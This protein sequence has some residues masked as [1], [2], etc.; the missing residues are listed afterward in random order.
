[1][2]R[3]YVLGLTTEDGDTRHPDVTH[4][5]LKDLIECDAD[6]PVWN[7]TW[8]LRTWIDPDNLARVRK[9]QRMQ[10][11]RYGHVPV[12][13]W[14]EVEVNEFKE[15]YEALDE[16]LNGERPIQATFEDNG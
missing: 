7:A 10:L 5:A 2:L 8:P 16:V 12:F 1:L 13:D 15:W 3:L 9:L 14:N 11:A 6:T 4:D